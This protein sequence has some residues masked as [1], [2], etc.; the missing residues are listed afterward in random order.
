M[1]KTPA[2]A[3]LLALTTLGGASLAEEKK[4]IEI[5]VVIKGR[6]PRPM[7]AIDVS[8]I[9]PKLGVND[10]RKP[11]TGAIEQVISKDPF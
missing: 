4:P 1:R 9:A 3:L 7:A 5:Q 2:L 11:S 6:I 8:R 10:L